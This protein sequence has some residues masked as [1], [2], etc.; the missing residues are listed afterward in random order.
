MMA[1]D[2]IRVKLKKSTISCTKGQK[3]NVKGL[4]LRKIG[5]VRTLE[6]TPAVRGMI[7][8]VIHM[9]EIKE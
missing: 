1:S 4:G 6:N 8:K 7:K 3:A 5:A 2:K 9:L